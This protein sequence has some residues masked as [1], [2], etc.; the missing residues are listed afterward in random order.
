MGCSQIMSVTEGSVV[1]GFGKYLHCLTKGGEGA[2][3]ILTL[4][5]KGGRQGLSN[6]DITNKNPAYGRHQ[7]S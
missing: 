3:K 7:L 6:A 1:G 4:A 5:D 2:W